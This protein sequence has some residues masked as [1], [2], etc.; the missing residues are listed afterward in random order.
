MTKD[1]LAT[2]LSEITGKAKSS[3][4]SWNKDMMEKNIPVLAELKKNQ[5]DYSKEIADYNRA[6][7]HLV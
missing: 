6:K 3:F 1:Q 4:M 7:L 5:Y 2:K